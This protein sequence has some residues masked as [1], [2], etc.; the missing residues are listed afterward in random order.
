MTDLQNLL[1]P[2]IS[3]DPTMQAVA[4]AGGNE[5][6]RIRALID[7]AYILSRIDSLPEAILDHLGWGLHID[8]WEY[9]DGISKKRWLVKNFYDW[10]AYKGTEHA[11]EMYWRVLLGRALLKASPPHKSY[12]GS[13]LTQAQREAFEAPHPEIRIYPFRHAGT[14][15]TMFLGDCLGDHAAGA[16][17]FPAWTDAILRAG[18]RVEL[19][20]PLTGVSTNLND[21][22][23]ERDTVERT[24]KSI[25]QIKMHG[26]A[27]GVLLGGA[28]TGFLV[29]H[30]AEKRFFTVKLEG[31][32]Q[33]DIERRT[34][35]SVQ[36]SLDPISLYYKL[37]TEKGRAGTG[38]FLHNRWP[39]QYPEKGGRA[40]LGAMHPHESKANLRIYKC[41]KLFDPDRANPIT[42][43]ASTFLG[44]FRIGAVPPH[45][46][47]VAVD[48]SG[49]KPPRAQ[50]CPGFLGGSYFYKS[51]AGTRIAQACQVGRMAKRL[52]DR[53]K[54]KI[55][56]RRRIKASSVIKAGQATAGEYRL[57]VI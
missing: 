11:L 3:G 9:A 10:H 52:S 36:P 18:D 45:T 50:H 24:A 30:K 20:D 22:L 27:A 5:E 29:D 12:L 55:T 17:V 2:S 35:L 26:K 33:T 54:L 51:D 40:Y 39:D 25:V 42:R 28:L 7:N 41:F 34:A 43:N 14:K 49:R 16:S 56:N 57:E 1:P 4:E 37:K 6:Q 48:M 23:I 53:I 47:E 21:V 31:V 46:A 38:A 13:S 19:H 44:A 8:G 32:Y 15:K